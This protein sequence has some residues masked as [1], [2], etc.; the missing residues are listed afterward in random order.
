M[1]TQ[2]SF[3]GLALLV[4]A[5]SLVL[6]VATQHSN[7]EANVQQ[8]ER[9]RIKVL[10][11]KDGLHLKP[12]D[13]EIQDDQPPPPDRLLEQEIPSNVP[14]KIKIR[15]EKEK[16]FKDVKNVNWAQDFELEVTNTGVKPIYELFFLL[17]TDLKAAAGYRIVTNLYYGR[18]ELATISTLATA[19]DIPIKPGE[20][21]ILKIH[22]GQI[23]A[24]DIKTREEHRP[25]PRKIK[26]KF[27]ILSFGDGTGF[28]AGGI[29]L[30]RNLQERSGL[31]RCIEQPNK[32]GPDLL[33]WPSV[34]FIK[35]SSS[36]NVPASTLPVNFLSGVSFGVKSFKPNPSPQDCCSGNDCTS[37]ISHVSHV[38]FNC[39]D[40]KD[41]QQPTAVTRREPATRPSMI[42]WN[43]R[44]G[45]KIHSLAK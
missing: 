12:T 14:I 42:R 19:E 37:L 41:L 35:T 10:R 9:T 20:S 1:S 45:M 11:R 27:Q 39:R 8:P 24:W 3:T 36:I 25:P 23:Q 26:I 17:S 2:K 43:V 7:G 34:R 33:D 44:L 32:R 31:S 28:G 16:E 5:A 21:I 13:K 30:P 18:A 38:C 22:P 29:A 15:K 6:I 40:Q 4:L